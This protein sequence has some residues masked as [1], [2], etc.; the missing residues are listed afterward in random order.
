[1]HRPDDTWCC[2]GQRTLYDWYG[3]CPAKMRERARGPDGRGQNQTSS[4]SSRWAGFACR[5]RADLTVDTVSGELFRGSERPM[6]SDVCGCLR[7]SI[8]KVLE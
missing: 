7:L 5:P 2:R 4:I 6:G 3:T 8:A 1:M